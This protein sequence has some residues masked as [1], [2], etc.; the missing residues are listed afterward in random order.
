M[1][2]AG[3]AWTGQLNPKGS[4]RPGNPIVIGMYG[5]GPKPCINGN[6]IYGS[7][8]GAVQLFNQDYWEIGNLNISNKSA[9]YD[10]EKRF[11]ILVRWHDYGTGQQV[12]INNC[13]IHDVSG[14]MKGRFNGEAILVVATGSVKSLPMPECGPI[15]P[16]MP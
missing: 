5:E 16:I 12:H 10:G 11:G 15:I 14:S 8:A 4:G 2:R 3:G 13:Q 6:G 1:F 9:S 7:K